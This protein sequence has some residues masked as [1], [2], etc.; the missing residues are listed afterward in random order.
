MLKGS[1]KDVNYFA[2]GEASA[3]Q[4]DSVLTD[5]DLIMGKIDTDE[6]A[7]LAERLTIAGKD[8]S[9]VKAAYATEAKRLVDA[10]K[11]KDGEVKTFA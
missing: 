6:I 8:G 5:V 9:A 11:L 7:A 2:D 10:G 3:A 1:V 4:V